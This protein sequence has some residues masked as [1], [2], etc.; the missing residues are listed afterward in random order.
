MDTWQYIRVGNGKVPKNNNKQERRRFAKYRQ[1][2]EQAD[3]TGVS[4]WIKQTSIIIKAKAIACIVRFIYPS[5]C[6]SPSRTHPILG[7]TYYRPG[8]VG[9]QST[10]S[11]RGPSIGKNTSEG[12]D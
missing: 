4:G 2:K 8:A 7:H 10:S 3:G 12:T 5:R 9:T 11:S 6:E 1:E